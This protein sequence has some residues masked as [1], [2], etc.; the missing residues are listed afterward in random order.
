LRP[1]RIREFKMKKYIYKLVILALTIG[2]FTNCKPN[3][4][5]LPIKGNGNLTTSQQSVSSFEKISIYS[6]ADVHFYESDE[7]RYVVTVDENLHKYVEIFTENNT[8]KIKTKN[9]SYLFT[10]FLVEVYCPPSLKS[11]SLSGSGNFK[12]MNIITAPMFEVI[13]PGSGNMEGT[14]ECQNFSAKILGSGEINIKGNC[15]DA[16]ITISGSGDFNGY[17]FSIKNADISISGS[18]NANVWVTDNLNANIS[19]SGNV[20]YRGEPQISSTITGSGKIRKM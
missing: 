18:G 14:V 1:T 12:G 16:N 8:L 4:S 17:D 9:G 11:V 7:F 20:N 6:S 15:I 3:T 13:I 19:G 5:I 2:I 10:K